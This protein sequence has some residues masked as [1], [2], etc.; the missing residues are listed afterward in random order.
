M[1]SEFI[2]R[3]GDFS[4][5]FLPDF[6]KWPKALGQP[7]VSGV[8]VHGEY[9]YAANRSVQFPIAVFDLSGNFIRGFGAEL[10][11]ARIHGLYITSSGKLWTCDDRNHIIYQMDLS[12]NVEAT[13]GERGKHCDNGYDPTVPWPHDLYTITRC[14]EPFNQPTRVVEAASGD[15]YVSDGYAN[16]AIHRFSPDGQWKQ[17]WGG[18]GHTD[19]TFRLPHSLWIDPLGRVWVCDRENNRVSVFTAEGRFVKSFEKMLWPSEPW[20]DEQHIYIG[21][22]L[23][24]ITIFNLDLEAVA[25]IGYEGSP[26]DIHS[27][28]GDKQGNLYAGHIH[29]RRTLTKLERVV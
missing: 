22:G 25:R 11:F 18:P 27:L 19:T 12:G 16:T 23:G 2:L 24:R 17:T 9:L 15:L 4:Y 7:Q 28:C 13:L 6:G 10:D 20:G 3:S 5:R 14:G 8:Y 21:E 26:L 1:Q 29:A